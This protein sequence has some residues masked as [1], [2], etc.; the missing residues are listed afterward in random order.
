MA[1]VGMAGRGVSQREMQVGAEPADPTCPL[2]LPNSAGQCL[3]EG[4]RDGLRLP[5]GEDGFWAPGP[6]AEAGPSVPCLACPMP[7][8]DLKGLQ[9]HPAEEQRGELGPH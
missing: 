9:L 4:L 2:V 8:P 1:W 7:G 5:R 6:P 3:G